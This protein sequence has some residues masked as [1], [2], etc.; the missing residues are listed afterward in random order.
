[1]AEEFFP[2]ESFRPG[3]REVLGRIRSDIGSSRLIVLRAPTGFGKTAVAI[4]TGMMKAPAIHSVRTR[5]E[6]TPVLRDLKR[7]SKRVRGVRYSFI[8]SAHAM[9][10]LLSS[11]K[12]DPEDFW[13]NCQILRENGRCSYYKKSLV[14]AEDEVEEILDSSENHV[15]VAKRISRDLGSCPFFSLARLARSSEYVV[16]TYPYVFSKDLFSTIYQEE[17]AGE[18]FAIVDEAHMLVDPSSIF[19]AEISVSKIEASIYEVKE[20][21]GGDPFSEDLLRRLQRLAEERALDDRLRKIDRSLLAI[22]IDSIEHLINISLEVKRRAI[23]RVL[24]RGSVSG[25]ASKRISLVKVSL[26]IALLE[27]PR[28]EVF[29]YRNGGSA[30]IKIAAVDHSVVSESLSMYRSSLLMSGTPPSLQYI[31]RILGIGGAS[32]IDALELG[33]WSPYSNIA[34]ILTSELSSRYSERGPATYELYSRYI[35]VIDMLINGVKLIIYPSYEFMRNVVDRLRGRGFM[36]HRGTTIEDLLRNVGS[37]NELIHAVAGGKLSEGIELVANN[38]SMIKCVFV[39]GVPYPQR[40]DYIEEL[41]KNM[42]KKVSEQEAWDYI[43]NMASSIKVLQAIG[44]AVRGENDRALVILGDRRFMARDIRK[45]MGLRIG[46]IA[47]NLREF[48]SLVDLVARDF[49]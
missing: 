22:D 45:Y 43:Y 21:L 47:R 44:R 40:D 1:M 37:G 3:Q 9:C 31:E 25:A 39:A 38:R 41:F 20:Y 49:L 6:I 7:L 4:A 11:D 48:E 26:S 17:D 46:R 14:V 34:T 36:E 24:S 13:L 15:D 32:Y 28:F 10:P 8:H 27:D 19:S 35:D 2:Y 29:T 16:A 42:G 12:I 30:W 18:F 23:D 33:A 5:N